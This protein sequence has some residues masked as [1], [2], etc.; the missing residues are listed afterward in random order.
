M[1]IS[2]TRR[3]SCAHCLAG[4]ATHGTVR[5]AVPAVVMRLVQQY[6]SSTKQRA[7]G[8]RVIRGAPEQRTHAGSSMERALW[9]PLA[10]NQMTAP[11]ILT[12][13]DT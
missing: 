4:L 7:D 1:L 5:E 10:S 6:K 13:L 8:G 12:K 11:E 9:K 2:H 3:S